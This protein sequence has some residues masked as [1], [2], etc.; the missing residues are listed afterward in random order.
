MM[1]TPGTFRP[2]W[3]LLA[4]S[5]SASP[6]HAVEVDVRPDRTEVP[7][8]VPVMLTLRVRG[9][10]SR[11]EVREPAVADAALRRVGEPT[12]QPSLLA[13]LGPQMKP[14]ASGKVP[15]QGLIESLRRLADQQAVDP[16]ALKALGDPAVAQEYQKALAS[17]KELKRDD[18]V[19]TYQ[20][21]P[22][23]PGR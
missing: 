19:F 23:R 5:L 18:Y 21:T 14:G 10:E 20:F 9:S 7:A 22:R 3:V 8:G 11:P 17:L 1:F 12:S 2:L 13:G 16:A 4:L 15:G 6:A